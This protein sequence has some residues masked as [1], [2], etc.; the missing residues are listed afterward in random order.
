MYVCVCVCVCC[1]CYHHKKW[2]WQAKVTSCMQLFAFYFAVMPL[3]GSVS[4]H[5]NLWK[6]RRANWAL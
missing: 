5:H 2:N 6:N 3:Y 4:S 1:N